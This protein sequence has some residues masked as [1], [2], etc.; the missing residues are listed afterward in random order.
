[1]AASF[2]PPLFVIITAHPLL[3]ASRAILPKGS[4][5]LEQTTQILDLASDF[6]MKSC[7][8]KPRILKFLCLKKY[9]SLGSSPITVAFQLLCLSK[10]LIIVLPKISNP[11][12][13][14]SRPT[15]IILF[16]LSFKEIFTLLIDW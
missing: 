4:S 2:R 11:F 9:F 10:I 13:L 15:K 3:E 16:C 7:F 1:M 5:H 12:D 6:N 14:L 8:L